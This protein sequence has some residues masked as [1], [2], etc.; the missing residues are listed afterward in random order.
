M[1][2]WRCGDCLYWC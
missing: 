1:I 2:D